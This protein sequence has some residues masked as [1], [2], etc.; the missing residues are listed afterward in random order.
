MRNIT[1]SAALHAIKAS[2]NTS[3][4]GVNG[5]ITTSKAATI[6]SATAKA[7]LSLTAFK[8]R[9]VFRSREGST[10]ASDSDNSFTY[11]S[12]TAAALLDCALSSTVVAKHS[13]MTTLNEAQK[14][15]LRRL[16]HALKPVVMLGSAGLT[17]AVTAEIESALTH[18]ELIKVKLVS[19]NR[20]Q[21]QTLATSIASTAQ[22]S[23]VQLIGNIILLYRPNPK[24]KQ[25]IALP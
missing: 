2:T 15:H 19:D 11:S 20:Q 16:G 25:R 23:L 6:H 17:P 9:M 24:K 13:T 22:A 4:Q 10:T 21:R 1:Q 3:S 5:T 8:S 14:R 7:R 18:H 12:A